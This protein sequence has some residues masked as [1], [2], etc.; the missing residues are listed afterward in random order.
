[1]KTLLNFGCSRSKF[2]IS[3]KFVQCRF[4]EPDRKTA[5]V[6]RRS[7][8]T[9]FEA[10]ILQREMQLLLDERDYNPR[11]K[12]FMFDNGNEVNSQTYFLDALQ[13]TLSQKEYTSNTMRSVQNILER[14]TPIVLKL[15]FDYLKIHEI[16]LQHIKKILINTE[17]SNNSYNTYKKYL[18]TLFSDLVDNGCI[19]VNPCT[20]LKR[21]PHIAKPKEILTDEEFKIVENHIKANYPE[22]ENFFYCF[23]YSACRIPELLRLKKSDVNIERQEFR[24]LVLKG[25]IN[26]YELRAILPDALPYWEKQ[27]KKTNNTDFLFS[28]KFNPG[29]TQIKAE[30]IYRWWNRNIKHSLKLTKTI[31]SLK[32]LLLDK[33]DEANYN[34]QIAAGHRNERTTEIY[35]VGRN[36][37]KLEAQKKIKL[38]IQTA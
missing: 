16:E 21:K 36:K 31:Y 32:H 22:F 13:K 18:S 14:I 28:Y 5:F 26:T 3:D 12:R 29:E 4:Y 7:Y 2:L 20:G 19:K 1:M 11:L 24:V 37:R 9:K 8:T 35:T 6:Y 38:N 34:A 25:G 23:F 30:L 27:L 17:L 33:L 10:K 15:G